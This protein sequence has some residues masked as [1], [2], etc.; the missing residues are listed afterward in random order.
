MAV[1]WKTG[2]GVNH[3]GAYQVSGRPFA[4]GSINA[5]GSATA[6]RVAFPNVTRWV[7]VINRDH[8]N[9]AKIG[10]S[11]HGVEKTNYFEIGN[12]P[13]PLGAEGT[14]ILE[15]KVSEIWLTGSGKIDIVAGLTNIDDIRVSSSAG[16][17]WSGSAGVG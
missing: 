16:N 4:S 8:A 6:T 14:P 12:A 9:A 2:V 5:T 15:V 13:S 1:S 11:Q 3:V 10:W 17:S 7:R